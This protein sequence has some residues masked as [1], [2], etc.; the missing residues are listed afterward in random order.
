MIHDTT[1]GN[2]AIIGGYTKKGWLMTRNDHNYSD[3]K[4][5]FVFCLRSPANIDSFISNV[6]QD[7]ASI[8][9][10]L[11][12][13]GGTFGKEAFGNF[14]SEHCTFRL[15]RSKLVY[16]TSN[17]NYESW[18]HGYSKIVGTA[19]TGQPWNGYEYE[20]EVFQTQMM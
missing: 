18:P 13:S 17:S 14:G 4:D 7:R 11:G 6:K 5:A 9:R 15:H 16:G 3:D 2:D 20:F 1:E 19:G 8:L 10:V 12:Y